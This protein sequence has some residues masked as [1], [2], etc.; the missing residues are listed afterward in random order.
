MAVQDIQVI[1]ASFN[2]DYID[3]P[4]ANF[5][6]VAK[7]N[8]CCMHI[9]KSLKVQVRKKDYMNFLH[10]CYPVHSPAVSLQN[11]KMRPFSNQH[12]PAQP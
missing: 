7:L 11:F 2:G 5:H 8:F 3:P 12:H 9:F 1:K 4:I 6:L 10:I